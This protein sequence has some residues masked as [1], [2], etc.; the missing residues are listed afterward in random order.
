MTST[1]EVIDTRGRVKSK[2]TLALLKQI[3]EL[4]ARYLLTEKEACNRLGV[5][6][7]TWYDFRARNGRNELY[8]RILEQMHANQIVSG[9]TRIEDCAHGRNGARYPDWRASQY[10]LQVKDKRFRDQREEP[11]TVN[12]TLVVVHD[13]LKRAYAARTATLIEQPRVVPR[14]GN[15]IPPRRIP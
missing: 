6:L 8:A 15:R 7:R 4:V 11:R 10:L 5:N 13:A 3:A 9:V 2:I 12:N 1:N 14:L